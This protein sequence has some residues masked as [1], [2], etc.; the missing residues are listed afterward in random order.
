[1]DPRTGTP[2]FA[3]AVRSGCKLS[4]H[5]ARGRGPGAGQRAGPWISPTSRSSRAARAAL[6]GGEKWESSH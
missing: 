1:M 5:L 3:P 6:T 2:R 4:T